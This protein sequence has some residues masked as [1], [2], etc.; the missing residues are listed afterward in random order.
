[1][2]HHFQHYTTFVPRSLPH[3]AHHPSAV[4][5]SAARAQVVGDPEEREL[6]ILAI[7]V[8][9]TQRQG[10]TLTVDYNEIE[11]RPDVTTFDVPTQ[12]VGFVLGAKGA[13]LRK[14]ES[15][16]GTCMF[17]DNKRERM[18]AGGPPGPSVDP[19]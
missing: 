1:M 9:L 16:H 10:S 2:R 8:A 14:I 11:R 19:D 5:P 18:A 15:K 7:R 13:S 6:A 3:R 12:T 17:F 4:S